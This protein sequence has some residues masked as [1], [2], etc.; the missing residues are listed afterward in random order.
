MDLRNISTRVALCGV[1]VLL[2]AG[3]GGGAATGSPS[4]TATSAASASGGATNV[5]VSLAEWSVGTSVATA[6]AGPVTF[7]VTN[8]GP[9]EVHEFVVIKTDLSM[10]ALPTETTGAV[11]EEDSGIEAQGEIEDVAVGATEELTL[12][13]APGAYVLICNI[14]DDTAKQSHYQ[15]GMRNQ[16]TVTP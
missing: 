9:D 13:L 14:Y 12:T 4:A 3:C 10:L 8:N 7:A 1:G 15:M 2:V 16:L 11:N 5:A 6:K